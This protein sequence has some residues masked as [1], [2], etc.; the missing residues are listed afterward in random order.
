VITLSFTRAVA[1]D[2]LAWTLDAPVA[3]AGWWLGQ[4]ADLAEDVAD[5]T[6]WLAAVCEAS[7]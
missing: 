6:P 2:A 4:L 3:W 7:P 1:I 5:T